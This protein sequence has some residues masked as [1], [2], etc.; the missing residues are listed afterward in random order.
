MYLSSFSFQFRF[1]IDILVF[2]YRTHPNCWSGSLADGETDFSSFAKLKEYRRL[3]FEKS[4]T[5]IKMSGRQV[6]NWNGSGQGHSYQ[7]QQTTYS[8]QVAKPSAA[9]SRQ[10]QANN[11]RAVVEVEQITRAL[12]NNAPPN[13]VT[14]NYININHRYAKK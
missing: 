2:V 10:I 13:S 5:E 7:Y 3:F 14:Y 8:N 12:A 6:D 9:T 11:R 4:S 1:Y